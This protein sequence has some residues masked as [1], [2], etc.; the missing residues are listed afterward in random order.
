[1]VYS[2]I[3]C[4]NVEGVFTCLSLCD[5]DHGSGTEQTQGE[6]LPLVIKELHTAPHCSGC[7]KRKSSCVNAEC[8]CVCACVCVCVCVCVCRA[9]VYSQH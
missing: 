3:D 9:C 1:M 2:Y 4:K 6:K 7:R 8:V 5:S